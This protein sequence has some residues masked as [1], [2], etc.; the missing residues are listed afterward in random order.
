MTEPTLSVVDILGYTK[1]HEAGEIGQHAGTE[2]I[3]KIM[4]IV[5][6]LNTDMKQRDI[7]L[8][9]ACGI[10]QAAVNSLVAK[11]PLMFGP[12][13]KATAEEYANSWQAT[14]TRS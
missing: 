10:V 3:G 7:A 13:V 12:L 1:A 5:G 9:I 8:A 4:Q 14:A 6:T 2:A 11:D